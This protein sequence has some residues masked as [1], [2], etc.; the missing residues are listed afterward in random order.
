MS[1]YIAG[2]NFWYRCLYKVIYHPLISGSLSPRHGASSGCGWRNGLY[3]GR[4]LRIY[5]N[6]S[7]RQP[8]RGGPPAWGLGEVLTTL[9]V[10]KNAYVTKHEHVPRTCTDTLVWPKQLRIRTG[11]GHVW[12]LKRTFGFHKMRG[13]S[14]LAENRLASQEGLC[15]M[16]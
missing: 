10:K 12:M 14:W 8:S 9:T 11:G 15:S 7:R 3:Y 16:E 6:S 1:L 4:Q 13:I 2:L 5:R